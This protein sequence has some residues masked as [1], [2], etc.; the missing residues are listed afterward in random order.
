LPPFFC[1]CKYFPRLPLPLSDEPPSTMRG[2][3]DHG[4]RALTSNLASQVRPAGSSIYHNLEGKQLQFLHVNILQSS[5][6]SEAPTNQT[7]R[8]RRSST[9]K[10]NKRPIRYLQDEL[11]Y[12][13]TRYPHLQ[14]QEPVPM[15]GFPGSW[16]TYPFRC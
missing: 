3:I 4:P 9:S 1:S 8:H 11:G 16:Y 2:V 5:R 7:L 13:C 14:G 10:E 15:G 12:N 6:D